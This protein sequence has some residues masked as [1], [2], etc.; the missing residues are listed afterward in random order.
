MCK[1]GVMGIEN[2][3]HIDQINEKRRKRMR[4]SIGRFFLI[5]T[6][7]MSV[8]VVQNVFAEDITGLI[9]DIS[10]RPNTIT[11]D[12]T[13]INGIPINYLLNKHDIDLFDFLPEGEY[14]SVEVTVSAEP[15]VCNSGA[16]KLMATSITFN[17]DDSSIVTI[18]LPTKE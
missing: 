14:E 1:A 11:I 8:V 7:V 3:L 17:Y 9:D 18:T 5:I 10:T 4:K 2:D 6:L 15:F 12:G 16:E 13:E